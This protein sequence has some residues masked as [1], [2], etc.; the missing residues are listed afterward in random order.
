MKILVGCDL[1]YQASGPA[2]LILNIQPAETPRQR[3]LRE[4]LVITPEGT[5][6]ESWT[7]PGT[8][9]GTACSPTSPGVVSRSTS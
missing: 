4:T 2:T 6:T 9:A 7:V 5:R 8:G 1:G 3:I